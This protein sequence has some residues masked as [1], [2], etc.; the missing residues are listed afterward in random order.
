MGLEIEFKWEANFPRSFVRCLHALK[1]VGA[2]IGTPRTLQI[3]DVYL[4]HPTRDFEQQKLAF[5]VRQVNTRWEA[6][7]KTRTELKNGRAVRREETC[8]LPGV[9]TL[10]QAL[11]YLH[12]KKSWKEINVQH[13]QPLFVIYNKRRV[14]RINWRGMQ[15]EL[16]L[17]TCQ[18][19]VCGRRVFLKEIELE[20]KK[21][22]ATL[23]E[24]L[25]AQLTLHMQLPRA[26]VSKVKT[27]LCLLKLWGEK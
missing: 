22:A 10:P 8:A 14:L 2:K 6:T 11:A 16:A 27:A 12:A 15:A 9:S 7:F 21:G 24:E 17:D 4:D 19:Q 25:V 26:R 18:L 1:Q 13:L 3:C 23:L 5:R 20:L